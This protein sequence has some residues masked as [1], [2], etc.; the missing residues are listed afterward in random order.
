MVIDAIV[1]F[2]KKKFWWY[3][4]KN[5]TFDIKNHSQQLTQV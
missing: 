1:N 4:V 5:V 2:G 3:Q